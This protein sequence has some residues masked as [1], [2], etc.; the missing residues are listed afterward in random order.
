MSWEDY[1]FIIASTYRKRILLALENKPK[2]PT[3]IALETKIHKGNV[4]KI[5]GEL[6]K[7]Q[8]VECIT[9]NVRKARFYCLTN[10]GKEVARKIR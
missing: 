4:S 1:S 7:K 5:L 3:Q 9:P 2:T 8:F 10:K 6:R